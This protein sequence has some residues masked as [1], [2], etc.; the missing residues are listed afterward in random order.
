MH[1]ILKLKL[2]TANVHQDMLV[3]KLRDIESDLTG[4]LVTCNFHATFRLACRSLH[5]HFD[6]DICITAQAPLAADDQAVSSILPIK[7]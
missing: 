4:L 6:S 5:C 7:R 3:S 1:T 2:R